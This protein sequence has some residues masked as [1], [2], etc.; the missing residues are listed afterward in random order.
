MLFKLANFQNG[1]LFIIFNL[2]GQ[3]LIPVS[4]NPTWINHG[5][6]CMLTLI[7]NGNDV[8]GIGGHVAGFP[9]RFRFMVDVFDIVSKLA[10]G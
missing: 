4:I 7:I 9:D 5:N 8:L 1:S 6:S 3:I 10:I 2:F